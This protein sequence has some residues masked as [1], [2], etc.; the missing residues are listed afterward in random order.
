MRIGVLGAGRM[1]AFHAGTLAAHPAVGELVIADADPERAREV[2]KRLNAVALPVDRLL[3]G[4]PDAVVI[5][6]A[7][8]AH[9]G[10]VAR[11][12]RAGIP[13]FCEKPI[14]VDLAGTV[15]ALDAVTRAGTLLQV[16]FQ[17]RF[18]AG[19][20]AARE[21]LR[22]GRVGRLHTVRTVSSD[23]APPPAAYVPLS[24][25]L[26]RDCL[27]HDFD[28]VRWVT[29]REVTEVYAAGTNEGEEFFRAAGDADTA[30]ALLTLEGGVLA[31]A[32]ATRYHAAG[33]DVRMELAGTAEQLVVGV[34]PRAPLTSVEP[35][36]QG[37]RQAAAGPARWPGFLERF[38]PAY[39]AELDA[40]LRVVRGEL[41]NPCEGREALRA[42]LVAEAC[43]VSRRER[44]PVAVAEM[45]AAA[46][47]FAAEVN[48]V[49]V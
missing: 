10:L 8:A 36:S 3:A 35:E 38:A 18:D 22:D 15:A 48:G 14:A 2:A 19:Y 1:G 40:F 45:E 26:Y 21:A 9:A 20:A 31:T 24:G 42:L 16:G 37:E 25:G 13:A 12:A 27:I 47:A 29:G 7:T 32:T 41:P 44:R 11:A 28:I 4:A 49:V 23:P 17:R 5:A 30:A 34:G 43:E 6:S 33:Y 46:R 39:R